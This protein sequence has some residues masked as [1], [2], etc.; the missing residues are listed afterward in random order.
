MKETG[1]PTP[2]PVPIAPELGEE[3]S[4]LLF[5]LERFLLRAM[6]EVVSTALPAVL[7][8]L[9]VNVFVVQ[10]M[11]IQGPS[12]QPNLH[13]DQ[14]VVVEKVTYRLAHGPRRGEVVI[15]DLPGEES[16]LIKR[17]VALPGETVEVRSGQV[18]INGQPLEESWTIQLGGLD[19]APTLVP[20]LH[21]FVL[22]DNRPSSR[23]SRYFGP[24]LV[25]HIVGRAL[26][27]CW[28][29]NEIKSLH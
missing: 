16:L 12:M 8:S 6:R 4:S 20:P 25:D 29:P 15:L 23:D 5:S 13:Y 2:K 10:A 14:R 24:V 9:F 27:V 11:T 21:V 18:L 22:G 7:A 19:Y 3:K 28:P 26:F 1:N 17:A